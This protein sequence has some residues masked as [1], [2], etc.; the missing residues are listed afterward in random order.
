MHFGLFHFIRYATAVFATSQE[1]ASELSRM[2]GH[3]CNGQALIVKYNIK[4]PS[5][6]DDTVRD[7]TSTDTR[8]TDDKELPVQQV[9]ESTPKPENTEVKTQS[10]VSN[11]QQG[12]LFVSIIC[13]MSC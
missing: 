10:S 4:N 9:Q 12:S 6:T 7:E 1:A 13:C 5:N 11:S 3:M 2:N 8:K